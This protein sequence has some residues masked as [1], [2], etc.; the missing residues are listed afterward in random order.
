MGDLRG[1]AGSLST[2]PTGRLKWLFDR[3]QTLSVGVS[4]LCYLAS[5]LTRTVSKVDVR[6][7]T[8]IIKVGKFS[9]CPL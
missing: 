4:L 7:A 2:G 9:L 8:F 6:F 1:H 5:E 3:N